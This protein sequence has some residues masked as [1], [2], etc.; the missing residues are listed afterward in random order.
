ILQKSAQFEF[1]HPSSIGDIQKCT[2]Y[3][4]SQRHIN[5]EKGMYTVNVISENESNL[6]VRNNTVLTRANVSAV[7]PK[8]QRISLFTFIQVTNYFN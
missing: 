4:L 7:S 3:F 2:Y 5:E 6:H 1:M 8:F